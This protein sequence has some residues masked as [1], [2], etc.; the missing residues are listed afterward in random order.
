MQKYKKIFISWAIFFVL[1]EK[2]TQEFQNPCVILMFDCVQS[3]FSAIRFPAS[4]AFCRSSS[5]CSSRYFRLASSEKPA[6][7]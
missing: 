6:S 2:K 7:S 5:Q 4:K 1:F 3:F